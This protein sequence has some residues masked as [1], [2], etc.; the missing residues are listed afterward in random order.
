MYIDTDLT[1]HGG[2]RLLRASSAA[3]LGRFHRGWLLVVG[4]VA[5][6]HAA[7]RWPWK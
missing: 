5:A 6:V 3:R 4:V 2:A 7:L 1:V